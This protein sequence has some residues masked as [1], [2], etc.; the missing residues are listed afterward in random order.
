MF[1][2]IFAIALIGSG[3]FQMFFRDP[4]W[5]IYL[6][7]A[8]THIRLTQLSENIPFPIQIPIV[9][10]SLTGVLYLIN[11][12]YKTKF[13]KWPAEVWLFGCMV[14]GMS[15]SSIGAVY[16][17]DLSWN[18][19][20]LFLK[21]TIFFL[22]FIN[23][24]DSQVKVEWFHRVMILSAA[25]LVYRCWDLRGTMGPRFE[26]IGGDVISDANHFA[27][28]LILLFP[29]VYLK[30]LSRNN[31]VVAGA[32]V[33]CFGMIMSVFITGSRGGLLGLGALA[34]LLTVGFKEQRKKI[35]TVFFVIGLSAIMFTNEYQKGRLIDLFTGISENTWDSSAQGRIKYWKTA[36]QLFKEHK[37][38]GIGMDNFQYYSGYMVEGKEPGEVG[39]V[40]HSIWFEMLSGGGMFVTVPFII[41]LIRFFMN[42]KK[43]MIRLR[44]DGRLDEVLYVTTIRIALG[45]F[46]VCAT[47]LNRLIYEPIYWCIGLGVI[48]SY[49]ADKPLQTAVNAHAK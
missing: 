3:F 19:T 9:I 16:R 26:N 41:I 45:A 6:F 4:V 44:N 2:F 32:A 42:T 21:F 7:A 47:F 22:I 48:H 36:L 18:F 8:L 46:L 39:H 24:I 10:A 40:T 25:W 5:G 37:L 27:A 38:A 49:L 20:L 23:M 43:T 34:V 29:F 12:K 15:V 35:I 13:S 17:P 30:T 31:W 33:L 28:A 1:K 11:G 14:L